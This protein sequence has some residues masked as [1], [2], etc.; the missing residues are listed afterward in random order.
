MLFS[1]QS[2]GRGPGN[3]IISRSEHHIQRDHR[4]IFIPIFFVIC[5]IVSLTS[6][7]NTTSKRWRAIQHRQ[8]GLQALFKL[9]SR[10]AQVFTDTVT[11]KNF[12]VDPRANADSAFK[13]ESEKLLAEIA[14][15]YPELTEH[16]ADCKSLLLS[17]TAMIEQRGIVHDLPDGG[18]KAVEWMNQARSTMRQIHNTQLTFCQQ[19]QEQL[20]RTN[21][22]LIALSVLGLIGAAVSTA[23]VT[24]Y[25]NRDL[26]R[27][28]AAVRERAY[29]LA[30]KAL[31]PSEKLGND[32]IGQ[33]DN[34]LVAASRTI[35][36]LIRVESA[37]LHEAHEVIC[38]LDQNFRIQVCGDSTCDLFPANARQHARALPAYSLHRKEQRHFQT[39]FRG[40]KTV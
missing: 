9:T 18:A 3:E 1:Q 17:F 24:F 6:T 34:A 16:S 22:A 27:R 20:E 23:L 4:L 10:L 30:H 32:E 12:R 5:L 29:A 13:G 40:C 15:D 35:Q 31:E 2:T 28:I 8:E 11:E 26:K 14:A 37:I 19:Q 39:K 38:S 33:A 21:G 7:I 25:F 36:D